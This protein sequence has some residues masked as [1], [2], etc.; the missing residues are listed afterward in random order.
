MG[1]FSSSHR[2]VSAT[3]TSVDPAQQRRDALEK[4]ALTAAYALKRN[5]DVREVNL[6]FMETP[7]VDVG[8]LA[9]LL[10]KTGGFV[11]ESDNWN[12]DAHARLSGIE[13]TLVGAA[14]QGR[15]GD[16]KDAIVAGMQLRTM[17]HVPHRA[18]KKSEG[19]QY[20]A[21]VRV[22]VFARS[23]VE[24]RFVL[25]PTLLGAIDERRP[26]AAQ[27]L[28]LGAAETAWAALEA[29]VSV[30]HSLWVYVR[31]D[32]YALEQ[33][34]GALDSATATLF[35]QYHENMDREFVTSLGPFAS[36]H[37][38]AIVEVNAT[39]LATTDIAH[40]MISVL[41][42]HIQRLHEQGLWGRC[43][44]NAF[45]TNFYLEARRLTVGITVAQRCAVS[46]PERRGALE[47]AAV[48]VRRAQSTS[49][50]DSAVAA[51]TSTP[52]L[53]RTSSSSSRS[54]RAVRPT[55]DNASG[56]SGR[57]PKH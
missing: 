20:T 3:S 49:L 13:H 10:A 54:L 1:V 14:L 6:F 52:T 29:D 22:R 27:Q 11:L 50:P 33:R 32:P 30:P 36:A 5:T 8:A 55:G 51:S 42:A 43:D 15:P 16:C 2:S 46:P 19:E 39:Q 26:S 28:V 9:R 57:L 18:A 35:R 25:A 23:I 47:S 53:L 7:G 24:D 12:R 17:Q 45:N 48:E 21:P 31:L 56:S 4:D 38:T 34:M 44:A 37:H 40:N 41:C